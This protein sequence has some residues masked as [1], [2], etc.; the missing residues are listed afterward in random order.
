MNKTISA[1]LLTTLTLLFGSPAVAEILSAAVTGSA[2]EGVLRDG[3]A[4]FQG[5]PFAAA[6]VGTLRWKPPQS[7]GRNTQSRAL[8]APVC[9]ADSTWTTVERRLPVPER[10][11]GSRFS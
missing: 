10:L 2:V 8:R 4:S 5:I 11:D 7:V 3:V 9:A 6:P 1:A